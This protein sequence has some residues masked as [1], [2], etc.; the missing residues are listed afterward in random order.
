MVYNVLCIIGKSLEGHLN[1]THEY[2]ANSVRMFFV[3]MK[4]SQ[5]SCS[6][7]LSYMH[8]AGNNGPF[9]SKQTLPLPDV[10]SSPFEPIHTC[11]KMFPQV[12]LST[13]Y[14]RFYQKVCSQKFKLS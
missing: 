5:E 3:T 10:M 1:I 4:L 2:Y 7:C 12:P 8:C 9:S 13:H 11:L 6:D 14:Q